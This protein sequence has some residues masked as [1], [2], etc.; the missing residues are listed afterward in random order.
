M[1]YDGGS[2]KSTPSSSPRLM[3]KSLNKSPSSPSFSSGLK[4]RLS[5]ERLKKRSQSFK[6]IDEEFPTRSGVTEVVK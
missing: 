6:S 1:F 4:K 3:K 5:F 2:S